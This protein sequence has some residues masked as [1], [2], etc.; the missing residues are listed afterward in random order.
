MTQQ[1]PSGFTLPLQH[2]M[3]Q[4]AAGPVYLNIA[5]SSK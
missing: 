3:L 4:G 5:M 2:E 1:I